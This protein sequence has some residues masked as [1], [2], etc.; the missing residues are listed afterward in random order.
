[1]LCTVC[2]LS[3]LLCCLLLYSFPVCAQNKPLP[4]LGKSTIKEVIKAMTPEKKVG[5]VV[6]TGMK[7]PG[8]PPEM[9]GSV[10]G[11]TNDKVTGAAGTTLAIPRL[12]IPSRPV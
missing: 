8:L 5:L 2:L 9:Q 10:V 12:D 1:M 11:Q 6:G 4:Q 3:L 7:F